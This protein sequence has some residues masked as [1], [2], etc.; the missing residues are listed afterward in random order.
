MK[1]GGTNPQGCLRRRWIVLPFTDDRVKFC[2]TIDDLLRRAE[3]NEQTA[4]RIMRFADTVADARVLSATRHLNCRDN[5]VERIWRG[6]SRKK[7]KKIADS[8]RQSM[9]IARG[10]IGELENDRAFVSGPG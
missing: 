6:S 3:Q 7:K 10:T 1:W 5:T 9:L 2:A 4:P 8:F